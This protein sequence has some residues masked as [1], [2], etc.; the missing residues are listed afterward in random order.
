M[1]KISTAMPKCNF[2]E[3]V[4]GNNGTLV[5]YRDLPWILCKQWKYVGIPKYLMPKNMLCCPLTR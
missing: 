1:F 5:S 3:N 4:S 2:K